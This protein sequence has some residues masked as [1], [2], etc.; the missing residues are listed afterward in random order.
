MINT[1]IKAKR[2]TVSFGKDIEVDGYQMPDGEFRVGKVGT[3]LALGFSKGWLTQVHTRGG[4]TLKTLQELGYTG[5]HLEGTVDRE[6]I[7]GSSDIDTISLDDFALLILYGAS[8]GKKPA[9]AL[10]LSLTKMSLSD[11]FRN[12]FG[13]RELTFEERRDAFFADIARRIDWKEEDRADWALIEE[14]EMFL[15]GV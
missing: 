5:S 12:A 13:E 10:Q 4:K 7:R 9:I 15:L 14:Q 6:R 3:S 2:A 8:Q 11:F 1:T